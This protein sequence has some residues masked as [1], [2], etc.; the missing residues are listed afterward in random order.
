[1]LKHACCHVGCALPGCCFCLSTDRDG[2]R[3][4]AGALF[5]LSLYQR[6]RDEW[7]ITHQPWRTGQGKEK[8]RAGLATV[9]CL[10]ASMLSEPQQ[11]QRLGWTAQ[12]SNVRS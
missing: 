7:P 8:H 5:H 2:K 11:I 10:D 12:A 4:D 3:V 1:M 6:E 9:D